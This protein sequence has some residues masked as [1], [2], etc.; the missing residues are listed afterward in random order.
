MLKLVSDP[1]GSE[2]PE[3]RTFNGLKPPSL[4]I[5]QNEVRNASDQ[6]SPKEL[7]QVSLTKVKNLRKVVSRE[8]HR[9]KHV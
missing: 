9:V 3:A 4:F 2:S 6:S 1:F 5:V 7:S 8:G